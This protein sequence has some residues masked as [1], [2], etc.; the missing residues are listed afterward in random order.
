MP[1]CSIRNSAEIVLIVLSNY[2]T[3]VSLLV[4]VAA[5]AGHAVDRGGRMGV[6]ELE[7]GSWR[8]IFNV[9]VSKSWLGDDVSVSQT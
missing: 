6:G 8:K 1:H 2:W 7:S 9:I 5:V 3:R 4:V